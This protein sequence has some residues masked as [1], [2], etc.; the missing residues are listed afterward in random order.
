MR[1]IWAEISRSALR[2]NLKAVQQHI[3]PDVTVCAVVKADAYGHGSVGCARV[4]EGE[5]V[6]WFGVTGTEEGVRLRDGGI[7]GRVLLLSGFWQGE[8]EEVVHQRLTPATYDLWQ[9][10]ALEE[11]AA[12]AALPE[13]FRFHLKLDTGMSRLGISMSDLPRAVEQIR[14]SPHLKLEGVFSHLASAEVLDSAAMSEQEANFDHA[15]ETILA[16]GLEPDYV[17]LANTSG[18][19]GRP[20]ARFNMVRPG[21]ALYGYTLP[22]MRNH[23][24]A[25]V[26]PYVDLKPALSWKT[27]IVSLRDLPSGRPVG[28]GGTYVT[29]RPTRIGVLPVGYAD[30]LNRALSGKGRFH[31]RGCQVP[32]LGRVSM[33]LTVVDVTDI[34]NAALGD[35]V[36]LIGGF[37]GCSVTAWDHAKLAHTIPYEIL[38]N[39]S[40]RVLRQMVD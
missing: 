24:P 32:I 3:G 18:T 25:T 34:P 29:T 8:A 15:R 33:D 10:T 4:L 7:H 30:G 39:I 14:Q 27:R 40:K 5:G 13:P 38:C 20:E 28:Y 22:F 23:S 37:N 36:C 35:E 9:I 19:I 17:H 1:P 11:A 31:I 2:H 6:Q 12:K 26:F 16:S 21:L